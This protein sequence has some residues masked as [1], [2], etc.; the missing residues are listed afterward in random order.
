MLSFIMSRNDKSYYRP[1]KYFSFAQ[2]TT[3]CHWH[4]WNI[5]HN[6]V[7]LLMTVAGSRGGQAKPQPQAHTGQSQEQDNL[8]TKYPSGTFSL[9]NTENGKAGVFEKK[10][11]YEMPNDWHYRNVTKVDITGH[12]PCTTMNLYYSHTDTHRRYWFLFSLIKIQT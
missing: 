5:K 8:Q 10:S 7:H 9:S 2:I 6:M 1:M 3:I 11:L 4:P 12:G